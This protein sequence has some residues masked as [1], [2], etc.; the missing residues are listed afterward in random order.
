[1]VVTLGA[2]PVAPSVPFCPFNRQNLAFLSFGGHCWCSGIMQDSNSCDLGLI[3]GQ[4]KPF[5]CLWEVGVDG[6]SPRGQV[7]SP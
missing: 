3:P 5:A 6:C 1:M 4:C 2:R 7:T